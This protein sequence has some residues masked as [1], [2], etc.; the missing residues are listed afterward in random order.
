MP[1]KMHWNDEIRLNIIKAMIK[2]N[3]TQPN[4]KKIK[5][6]TGYH[7]AT[8]K[9]TIEYLKKEN[10]LKGFGPKFMFDKLGYNLEVIEFF[11]LDLSKE[12]SF[13][14]FI[15]TIEQDPHVY[16]VQTIMGSG[17]YNIAMFQFYRTIEEFQQNKEKNYYQ[18]NPEFYDLIKDKQ[19]FYL[20]N[21]TF[22]RG[23]RSDNVIDLLQEE[24]GMKN[25]HKTKL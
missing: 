19:I 15:D 13:E 22:K 12:K 10:M 2:K 16:A 23:S 5:K 3:C 21:P 6:E 8:I 14:K 25:E 9:A 18:K 17:N 11:Q 7:L 4:L 20:T 1:A 24:R